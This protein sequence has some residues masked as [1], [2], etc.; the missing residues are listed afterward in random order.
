MSTKEKKLKKN[1]NNCLKWWVQID[2]NNIMTI[3][4]G[5]LGKAIQRL[6]LHC[7]LVQ[8]NKKRKKTKAKQSKKKKRKEKIF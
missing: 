1:E 8:K 5:W 2:D 6:Q 4:C 7:W 3:K